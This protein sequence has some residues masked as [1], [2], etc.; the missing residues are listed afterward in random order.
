MT[1]PYFLF[2]SNIIIFIAYCNRYSVNNCYKN[3]KFVY[4]IRNSQEL[5][6]LRAP[7]ATTLTIISL[8]GQPGG[9]ACHS[10]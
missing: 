8:P 1:P 2:N 9:R 3:F 4:R 10:F 5:Q 6:T 7:G